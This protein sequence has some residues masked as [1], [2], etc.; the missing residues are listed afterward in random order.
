MRRQTALQKTYRLF[1]RKYFGNKL[2]RNARLRWADLKGMM[3][4]QR[5]QEI[6]IDRKDRK[7]DSVWRGTLLHEMV[8][9]ALPDSKPIG[10][11]HGK[12]FQ[13]E[14]MRI[15]RLGALKGIW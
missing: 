13:K 6:V 9:L 3:G 14:M 8:H 1:N 11:F 15:A 12:D 7:R 10:G 2:P 5:G 4:Y